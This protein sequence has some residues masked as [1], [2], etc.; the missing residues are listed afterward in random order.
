M[1]AEEGKVEESGE[2]EEVVRMKRRIKDRNQK[3][4]VQA[5]NDMLLKEE[6]EEA[7][8]VPQSKKAK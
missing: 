6:E 4:L 7:N 5:G 2:N 3:V 8:T 1:Q